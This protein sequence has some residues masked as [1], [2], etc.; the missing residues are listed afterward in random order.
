MVPGFTFFGKMYQVQQINQNQE[1][2]MQI[3]QFRYASDNFSYLLHGDQSAMAIDAGAI[4]PIMSYIKSLNLKLAYVTN[5]HMH[6]DHISG[7]REILDLT[8]AEFLDNLTLRRK[9]TLILDKEKIN[10][11]H[12]PGHTEDSLIFHVNDTIVSGDTLFNGTVGN[13]FSG[14]LK[15]F[16]E[17]IQ[18]IFN[19]PKNT[20][21]YAGHDYVRYAMQF[22]KT[23]EPDNQEIDLFLSNYDP[24]HVLSTLHDELKI[25]PYVRFNDKKIISILK[26]KGLPVENEYVRWKS[27][28]EIY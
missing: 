27:L 13:C 3:K 5:T 6:P 25:N 28:M 20:I 18:L 2:S 21:I 1:K 24:Y 26:N 17:S 16:F 22:A 4:E 11:Y 15:A 19:F 9:K 10:V 12:T 23:I 8:N 14:N 7:N